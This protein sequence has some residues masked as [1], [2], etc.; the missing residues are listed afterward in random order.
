[1]SKDRAQ[2][3]GGPAEFLRDLEAIQQLGRLTPNSA[4]HFSRLSE[5]LTLR[6]MNK[7]M[8]IAPTGVLGSGDLGAWRS[9]IEGVN[10]RELSHVLVDGSSIDWMSSEGLAL[11]VKTNKACEASGLSFGIAGLNQSTRE[12]LELVNLHMIL[13]LY[14]NLEEAMQAA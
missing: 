7:T 9:L 4:A 2:R 5:D 10:E 11:L 6:F 14:D 3:P 8:V 13:K 12:S 1:M